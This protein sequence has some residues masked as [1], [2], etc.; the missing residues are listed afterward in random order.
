MIDGYIQKGK[1][2]NMLKELEN[3]GFKDK[4]VLNAMNEVPRHFYLHEMFENF[5]Y[6]DQAFKIGCG[7]TISHPSTVAFQT[8]LLQIQKGDKILEIG[9]GCGY[10]T[11]VLVKMGAKVFSIE[12]QRPLYVETKKLLQNLGV[13]AQLFYGDGYKGLPAFAPFDKIIVTAGAPFIPQDLINQLDKNGRMVIPVGE[14]I[15]I[16]TLITK[17]ENGEVIE[18][19]LGEFKF[20]PM[21]QDKEW[22]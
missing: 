1:R 8:E 4:A 18:E 14:K 21:L 22:K 2:L 12:R 7:Q 15:Q 20:V 10:Q 16:M 6:E 11:S 9:T 17:N 5:A 13:R 3:K 19:K